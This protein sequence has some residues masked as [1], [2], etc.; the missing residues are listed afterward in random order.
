MR[1]KTHARV[2]CEEEQN[3]YTFIDTEA[4]MKI[5]AVYKNVTKSIIA[6]LEGGTAPWIKPSK[7]GKRVG[8]MPANEIPRA[9]LPRDQCPDPVARGR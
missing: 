4:A 3:N 7:A 2:D 5:A 8:I 9:P 6:E 1:R